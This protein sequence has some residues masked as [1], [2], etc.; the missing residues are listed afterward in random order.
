MKTAPRMASVDCEVEAQAP[1]MTSL[2]C[3]AEL[4]LAE[5]AKRV[6]E[7]ANAAPVI[8]TPPRSSR[9]SAAEKLI[10]WVEST[11]KDQ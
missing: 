8:R 7:M 10:A 2:E 9:L 1:R 11:S 4:Q 6:A 5:S 3:E